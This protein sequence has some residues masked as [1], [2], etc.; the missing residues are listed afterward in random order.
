MEETEI[1]TICLECGEEY[2]V[3]ELRNHVKNVHNLSAETNVDNN[4]LENSEREITCNS[5]STSV[6]SVAL[7][8]LV[9]QPDIET[10][11]HNNSSEVII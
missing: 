10:N 2:P 1:K 4:S 7:N 6:S 5:S 8:S 3:N 11:V 9:S